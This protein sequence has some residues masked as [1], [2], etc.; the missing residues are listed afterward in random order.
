MRWRAGWA[1]EPALIDLGVLS[2]PLLLPS[3]VARGVGME[4]WGGAD[5]ED[6][7]IRVL[8]GQHRLLLIDNC[9]HLRTACADLL[10]MVLSSCPGLVVLAT[11]RE[12][13]GLPG[14]VA[15]R[16][17][18]L[19]LPSMEH[20]LAADEL[21]ECDAAALFLERARAARPGLTV[22]LREV[23]EVASIRRQLDGIPLALELA[24]AR[25]GA[26]SLHEIAERL[27]EN[28]RL[29]ARTA[30]GPAR[31][32]TLRA[33][34]TW[35]HQLLTESEQVL[36]RRLSVFAGGW[37]LEVAERVCALPPVA[38]EEVAGLLAALV[39]K[40]LVH[41]DHQPDRTRYRLLKLIQAFAAGG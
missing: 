35:S 39:D 2:D 9:E 6:R 19:P 40:S 36:F 1:M 16:V 14:E 20:L 18:P 11:S 10:T 31:Q 12:P 30:A 25:A 32:Q 17:P 41:V 37:E 26:L 28:P 38:T 7:L 27:A 15:L 33:S 5:L 13:L 24:A 34:V 8:R 4:E 29:L 3:A 21:E 22:G 23:T